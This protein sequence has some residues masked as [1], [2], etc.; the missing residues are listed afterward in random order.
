M[1]QFPSAATIT[2]A[3]S[4]NILYERHR[5]HQRC[6]QS[7]E[8]LNSFVA[9]VLQLASACDFREYSDSFVRDRIVFGLHDEE[10]KWRIINNGGNPTLNDVMATWER[11]S[12]NFEGNID[13]KVHAI[14]HCMFTANIYYI[15]NRI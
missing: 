12:R 14:E 15:S 9:D 10:I 4:P 8:T 2:M 3:N 13:E 11:F 7:E 5:F 1:E 6:Q